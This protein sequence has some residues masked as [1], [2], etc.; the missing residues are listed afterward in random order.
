MSIELLSD[1]LIDTTHHFKVSAGPGAGKTFW[2]VNHIK[3][4]IQNSKILTASKK[5]LCITYT[6]TAAETI[7]NRLGSSS[8][9]VEV[10]TIHSFLYNHLIK[11]YISFI[12]ESYDFEVS[13]LDGHDDTIHS[14][15]QF[16]QEWKTKTKQLRIKDDNAIIAA[17][18][19]MRW[20]LDNDELIVKPD[21]PMKADDYAIKNTSYYEYKKMAWTKGT[22]H[23]DDVLFFAFHIL[24]KFPYI[25]KVIS[26][27]FPYIFIDEFQDS[28][29]I[30]VSIIKNFAKL[31]TIGVIGD[32]AQSIYEFQ[33]ADS[34]QFQTFNLNNSKTYHL[35]KNRRSSNEIIDFLNIIRTD[36]K[37]DYHRNI[38]FPKPILFVGDMVEALKQAKTNCPGENIHTL[39][40][41]NLTSNA[42]KIEING[43]SLD[44]ELLKKLKQIDSNS[45]RANLIYH[46]I[47]AI[48][49][50]KESKFKEAIKFLE[51]YITYKNDKI[52]GKKKALRYLTKMLKNFDAYKNS[53]LLEFSN[54]LKT[55]IDNSLAKVTAGKAKEFYES[56]SFQN[57][58]LCV[59]ILEDTS[60]NRTIH[61]SK[62]DEFRNV[63][64]VVKDQKNL[65]FIHSPKLHEKEEHRIYYVGVSRAQNRLFICVPTLD[66]ETEELLKDKISIQTV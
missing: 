36:L 29:P 66:N 62:G 30:Q 42:M 3:N 48:A 59:N 60:L 10:L 40:W 43:S 50:A 27:K 52:G 39:A 55:E 7:Q 64:L 2:V 17:F 4:V 22:L 54:Y 65:E 25:S 41:D 5:I 21:Y 9:Q 38:S 32:I 8:L 6:N 35:N 33:G 34:K 47:N 31:S 56:N 49:L 13:S 26:S 28:N 15:Y 45:H 57:L 53:S 12:A 11:P 61:K 20:K 63:L 23:H 19:R 51:K 18:E 1:T 24:K 58:F 37:Q 14:N 46:S 16:I 44:R